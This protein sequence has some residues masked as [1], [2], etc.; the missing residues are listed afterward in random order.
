MGT[1]KRNTKLVKTGTVSFPNLYFRKIYVISWGRRNLDSIWILRANCTSTMSAGCRKYSSTLAYLHTLCAGEI[2]TSCGRERLCSCSNAMQP[3]F[4]SKWSASGTKH[5][6][7]Y[8]ELE[9]WAGI[10]TCLSHPFWLTKPSPEARLTNIN[11]N[12][13][14]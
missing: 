6:W 4:L 5:L 3:V 9:F 11:A 1:I 14:V 8:M 7:S 2:Q 10:G 12:F 13:A